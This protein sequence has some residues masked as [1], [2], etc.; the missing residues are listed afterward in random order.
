MS[1]KATLHKF[2]SLLAR[3][4]KGKPV[5]V[6]VPAPG[7]RHS[8]SEAEV[9]AGRPSRSTGNSPPLTYRAP[10]KSAD[11]S[12]G[13]TAPPRASSLGTTLPKGQGPTPISAQYLQVEPQEWSNL[14]KVPVKGPAR[15]PREQAD[16]NLIGEAADSDSASEGMRGISSSL[17]FVRR[18]TAPGRQ[19]SSNVPP[20]CYKL[21]IV[22]PPVEDDL[23]LAL[24]GKRASCSSSE[25]SEA[26]VH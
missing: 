5:T 11:L 23:A 20:G 24:A 17:V 2:S 8:L 19:G 18:D 15:K 26:E 14:S 13:L 12:D 3:T 21:P 7:R 16:R 9:N 4:K 10:S 6:P 1:L 25:V 22:Q